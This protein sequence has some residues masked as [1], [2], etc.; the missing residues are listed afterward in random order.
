[1]QWPRRINKG[2]AYQLSVKAEEDIMRLYI[3]GARE[4]GAE[5]AENYYAGLENIFQFLSENPLAARERTEIT[6][7]VRVH[8]YRTHIV[9]YMVKASGG[10]FILRVRHGSEDWRSN[11]V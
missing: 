9:V 1:V 6:P 2:M 7:V 5:Q 4:F 11:P 8:P 10:I 3:E